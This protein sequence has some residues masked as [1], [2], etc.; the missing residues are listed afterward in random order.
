MFGDAKTYEEACQNFSWQIPAQYNL[1][2]D[3]CDRLFKQGRGDALLIVD[4]GLA[5]NRHSFGEL[6]RLSS[7][8]ANMLLANGHKPGDRI[9]V[10]LK[11]SLEAAVVHLGILKAGMVTVPVFSTLPREAIRSRLELSGASGA[12]ATEKSIAHVLAA[13]LHCPSL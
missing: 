5:V 1:A 12:V 9:L 7:K 2:I 6:S 13:Q 4:N 10:L 8:F 3:V 11:A